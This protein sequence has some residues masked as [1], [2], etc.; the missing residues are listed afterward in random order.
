M[1]W[2]ALAIVGGLC[3]LAAVGV[4]YAAVL[5][6]R[7]EVT[8]VLAVLSDHVEEHQK[9]KSKMETI[10]GSMVNLQ[11]AR[12]K[13]KELGAL[14]ESLKVE[15]GRITITQ[16]ELETVE[17]RLRELEEIEREL[18]ASALETK[19]ELKILEKKERELT[20][21]N[22]NLKREIEE[23]LREFD[24]LMEEIEMSAQMQEQV[25]LMKTDLLKTQAQ[26]D[27]L[28]LQI[29]EGNDQYLVLKKRYDALD[30]EYAQL[31]E[32]FAEIEEASTAVSA[33]PAEGA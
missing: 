28:M 27:T 1:S 23:S 29:E 31:Y 17:N 32:K 11:V 16:A 20:N 12:D 30:I 24:Q 14:Q 10:Y 21:K 33:A 25:Q 18:Q 8:K 19:E 3:A 22:D 9:L 5:K 15:R 7:S 6:R 13:V 4:M 2:L 26:I